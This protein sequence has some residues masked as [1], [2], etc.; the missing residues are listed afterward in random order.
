MI[1]KARALG[2][3]IMIGSMN[4]T[5]IG[6]AAIGR[7]APLA[8]YLDMDGPLLLADDTASGIKYDNGK[9][10]MSDLPGLGVLV[11]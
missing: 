6:S 7:L 11:N 4:E 1:E 10:M 3:K 9:V 2:L 5:S 8:D